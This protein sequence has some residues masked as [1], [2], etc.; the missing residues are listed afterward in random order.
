[1]NN[2]KKREV[3]EVNDL[4]VYGGEFKKFRSAVIHSARAFSSVFKSA[5]LCFFLSFLGLAR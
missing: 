3:E 1:M 5:R 2:N 4:E